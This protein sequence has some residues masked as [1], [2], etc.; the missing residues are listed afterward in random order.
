MAAI[1]GHVFRMNGWTI[2]GA[3]LRI[4]WGTS[5]AAH[6][7]IVVADPRGAAVRQLNGL[8]SWFDASSGR[9]RHK[10]IGYLP[11]DRLRGYDTLTHPQTFLPM[12]GVMFGSRQIEGAIRHGC[13]RVLADGLSETG[14]EIVL[15]PALEAMR[16]I[17]ALSR[18]AEGGGGLP[19]PFMGFGP[20]SNS[21][22]STLLRAMAFDEPDFARPAYLTPGARGLLLPETLI[23]EIRRAAGP[24]DL[25][26]AV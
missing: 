14:A 4:P 10:P 19:Y 7:M 22:F 18:G 15:K 20:N 24:K 2:A 5:L 8:A 11:T 23:A 17:N 9:W 1:G 25:K 13:M 6:R 12:N 3:E 26:R 16:R 21:F